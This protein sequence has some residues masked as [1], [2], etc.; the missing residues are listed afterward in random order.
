VA[1]YSALFNFQELAAGI[2][3]VAVAPGLQDARR[4]AGA[5]WQLSYQAI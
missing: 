3:C 1:A 2:G 4:E 5:K